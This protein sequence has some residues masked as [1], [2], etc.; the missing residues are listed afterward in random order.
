MLEK[1][2]NYRT[3]FQNLYREHQVAVKKV[4]ELKEDQA[5]MDEAIAS[6]KSD[7]EIL[8]HINKFAERMNLESSRN[9]QE[10]KT[11]SGKTDAFCHSS[12]QLNLQRSSKLVSAFKRSK[13]K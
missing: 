12:R 2:N 3:E 10:K 5:W 1:V 8:A 4:K 6:G 7:A 11:Q 9:Q 13:T